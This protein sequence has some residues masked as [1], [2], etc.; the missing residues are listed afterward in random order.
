MPTY[1]A[2]VNITAPNTS[3]SVNVW[4]L[5]TAT[6]A[7]DTAGKALAQSALDAVRTMYNSY[8]LYLPTGTTMKCDG[9]IDVASDV[10]V[11]L[12]WP[13]VGFAGTGSQFPPHL[14]VCFGW[15]TSLR[16][17]RGMGRTFLG[18]LVVGVGEADGTIGSAIL[19]GLNT[20]ANTL[21]NASIVDNGWAIGVYGQQDA[22]PGASS[23]QRA[24]APHVLRDL[25]GVSIKDKFAVMR[26]RRP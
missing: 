10:G 5:R 14:A 13:T 23:E 11:T 7:E 21:V 3:P 22:M 15:K 2:V 1:K 26:S 9:V 6:S 17:R 12:T 4:H 8:S 24:L 25:V 19:T 18:P 20:A 16:A